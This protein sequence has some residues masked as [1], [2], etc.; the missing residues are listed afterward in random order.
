MEELDGGFW[1]KRR[2]RGGWGKCRSLGGFAR[3]GDMNIEVLRGN[4]K[5]GCGVLQQHLTLPSNVA[6]VP[7]H[8]T[9][10]TNKVCQGG[11]IAEVKG[12]EHLV[13]P[14]SPTKAS[15]VSRFAQN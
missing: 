2:Q 6:M 4:E 9:L 3:R 10:P 5:W 12:N 15:M 8:Q 13:I 14:Q 1:L 7:N 11:S